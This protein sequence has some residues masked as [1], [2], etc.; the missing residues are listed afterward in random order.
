MKHNEEPIKPI[1]PTEYNPGAEEQLKA[2]IGATSD[3]IYEM[4]ADWKE[5]LVAYGK[6]FIKSID[7]PQKDWIKDF[8]P[9]EDQ[10]FVWDTIQK[11]I[12]TK[13]IFELEHRVLRV[14]GTIG[15]THSK[16]IPLLDQEGNIVKWFGA[17]GDISECK[18]AE[19]ALRQSEEC[20]RKLFQ[21]MHE[22]YMVCEAIREN[23]KLIDYRFLQVNPA[24]ER[25]TGL[26]N[27]EAIGKT[28][29]EAFPGVSKNWF[30]HYQ[31]VIDT[32]QTIRIEDYIA[33]LNKWFSFTIF[34]YAEEQFAI[35]FDEITEPKYQKAN[36]AFLAD[37]TKDLERLTKPEE[38]MEILGAK[39]G[40]HFKSVLTTFVE[41][42]EKEER[43]II[44]DWH[45]PEFESITGE[46]HLAQFQT[47]LYRKKS[48]GGENIVVN[49]V[50]RTSLVDGKQIEKVFGVTSFI[51][52]PIVKDGQ[53][54][55]TLGIHDTMP[56]IWRKDEVELLREL[57][58]RIWARLEQQRTEET[59]REA[60]EKYLA[61]FNT[62][63]EGVTTIEVIFDDHGK[64][65]DY[66][67]LEHNA[68]SKKHSGVDRPV[69]TTARESNPEIEEYWMNLIGEVARTGKPVYTE[70]PSK[71]LDRW[72]S[73]HYSRV[74]R[75]GSHQVVCVYKDITERKQK[76]ARK[77]I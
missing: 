61:L 73:V 50:Y 30:P 33:P 20:Y 47:E 24:I 69:G 75:K 17:A 26:D 67:Y 15:W 57:T 74:G 11:A 59:L 29:L 14:N 3:I 53:W 49:N 16:A 55:F 70:H 27:H 5:I 39:I 10:Q 38:A 77:E 51:N 19:E 13:S 71:T 58:N 68:M 12:D 76:E 32:R 6:D 22:G 25:L 43:G 63:D 44:R 7:T 34:Y 52:I 8:I 42:F 9:K 45:S 60:K 66:R 31:K 65:V 62:V 28:A 1:V 2:F 18:L 56:R 35:L 40:S 48:R 21:S 72:F 4:S 46:F 41:I 36:L 64:A 54:V 37:I 23:G